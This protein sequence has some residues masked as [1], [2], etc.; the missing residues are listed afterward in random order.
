VR[1]LLPPSESKRPGGRG[2]SIAERGLTGPLAE[3]RAALLAALQRLVAGEAARAAGALLL[4]PGLAADALARNAAVTS[5]HTMPALRRYTGVLYDA[6][7]YATLAPAARRAAGRSVW[8]FSGLWGVLRGDEPVPDYRVPA[9]ATLPGIGVAGSAWRPALAA[10]L[11]AVVAADL[12]VDLRSSDYA[13]MW[14]PG[15]DLA[16]DLVTV[17]VLSP[18]PRGGHGVVSFASKQGK[19]LLAR[20][21]LDAAGRGAPPKT[22]DDVAAAWLVAGGR[23]A[24]QPRPGELVLRT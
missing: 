23:D 1:L 5:A 22:I 15:R 14:R 2:R 9:K 11:P 6:W 10:L 12:V 7:G 18:L 13:A 20:A 16:A 17:R 19:G 24:D 8:I 3:T 4:P 21:L